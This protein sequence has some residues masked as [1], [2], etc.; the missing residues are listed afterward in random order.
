MCI[1]GAVSIQE[2]DRAINIILEDFSDSDKKALS[3]GQ[4]YH[5]KMPGH[6]LILAGR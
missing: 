3:T 4:E 1:S 5:P 2:K 6:Q